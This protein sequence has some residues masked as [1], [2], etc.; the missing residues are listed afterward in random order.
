MH[1]TRYQQIATLIEEDIKLHFDVGD[2]YYSE[3]TLVEKYEVNRHTIRRALA[4]LAQQGLVEKRQGAG[5]FVSDKR[6]SYAINANQRLSHALAHLDVAIRTELLDAELVLVKNVIAEALALPIENAQA[7]RIKTLRKLNNEVIATI[8][9]YF[10][11]EVC[12]CLL[13]AYE[14]G[15]LGEFLSTNCGINTQRVSS[16][17]SAVIASNLD[18]IYLENIHQRPVLKVETL[19]KDTATGKPVEY[20]V[21]R[22]R[23]DKI[24][25]TLLSS[26]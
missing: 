20:S 19:S 21:T 22:F 2:L 13:T 9:H 25:L 6:I 7:I 3:N 17:I 24:A 23:S 26:D 11:L 8:T 4:Q 1:E 16:S 15:S 10:P 18:N 5:C 14:S 12:P